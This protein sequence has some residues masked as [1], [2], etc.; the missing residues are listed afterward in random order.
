MQAIAANETEV[1]EV[2]AAVT[3]GGGKS[4]PSHRRQTFDQRGCCRPIVWVVPR[5]SLKYQVRRLCDAA[6]AEHPESRA[7]CALL[8]TKWT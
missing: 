5:E 1:C 7:R 3:P 4:L 6:W 8:P 2:L